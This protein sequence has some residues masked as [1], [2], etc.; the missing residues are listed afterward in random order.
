NLPAVG[1]QRLSIDTKSGSF[2][3]GSFGL[4]IG[5]ASDAG[6]SRMF[7]LGVDIGGDQPGLALAFTME[8]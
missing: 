4:G 6:K 2:V 5:W 8:F 3:I 1:L 7:D